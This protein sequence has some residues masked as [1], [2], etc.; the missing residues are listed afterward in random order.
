[1]LIGSVK[2][3]KNADPNKYKDTGYSIGFD[4]RSGLFLPDRSI[5]G[6]IIIFGADMSSSGHADNKNKD[7]LILGEGQIWQY[8]IN[9]RSKICY[10]TQSGKRFVLNLHYNGKQ[11]FY[12]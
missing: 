6:K 7:I 4:L 10:F 1:M 12:F 5:G 2:L 8:C 3:T 11:F 9:S